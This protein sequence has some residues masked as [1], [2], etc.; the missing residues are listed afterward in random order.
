MSMAERR[1]ELL[2]RYRSDKKKAKP[3]ARRKTKRKTKMKASTPPMPK[4]ER[5]AG[6]E[7]G[8]SE[9]DLPDK[10]LGIDTRRF[11]RLVKK[12]TSDQLHRYVD[13]VQ[14][15]SALRMFNI[16][17]QCEQGSKIYDMSADDRVKM[18]NAIKGANASANDTLKALN[19]TAATREDAELTDAALQRLAHE[20]IENNLPPSLQQEYVMAKKDMDEL[21]GEIKD[22]DREVQ[23]SLIEEIRVPVTS[24]TSKKEDKK[25]DVIRVDESGIGALG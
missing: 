4:A 19:I 11:L 6:R 18:L 17:E 21:A 7:A 25:D 1:Q 10:V 12:R 20:E 16:I 22:T 3:K 23:K 14:A 24:G 2:D 13:M 8:N 15:A 5:K 9:F